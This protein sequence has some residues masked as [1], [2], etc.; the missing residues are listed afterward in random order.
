MGGH[1]RW[2]DVKHKGVSPDDD[3]PSV[4]PDDDSRQ[5]GQNIQRRTDS[6]ECADID[7]SGQSDT[8]CQYD[9]EVGLLG[10]AAETLDAAAAEIVRL[11]AENDRMVA[12]LNRH[13][14]NWRT[15]R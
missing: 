14:P 6:G 12:L 2:A 3:T 4:S 10:D 11:R 8:V 15:F 1:K 9:H 7:T 13:L 5:I